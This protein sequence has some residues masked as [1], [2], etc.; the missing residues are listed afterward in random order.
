MGGRR[1]LAWA[2]DRPW[3][4]LYL[5]LVDYMGPTWARRQSPIDVEARGCEAF[6][7]PK[8]VSLEACFYPFPPVCPLH[9]PLG[10][11]T[12]ARTSG[13]SKNNEWFFSRFRPTA[14]LSR[15][16]FCLGLDNNWRR[17]VQLFRP[18]FWPTNLLLSDAEACVVGPSWWLQ[19]FRKTVV[20]IPLSATFSSFQ[21]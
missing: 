11:D 9:P 8:R 2:L 21:T 14:A 19:H 15:G 20:A 18:L 6:I 12:G 7:Q 1:S 3:Q 10:A 13:R 17:L 5:Y 16:F 4:V